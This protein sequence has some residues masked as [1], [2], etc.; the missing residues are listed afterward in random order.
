MTNIV[1][2]DG[3][4]D[5]FHSGHINFLQESKKQGNNLYV[6]V[7]SDDDAK[8][9]K[10][11]PVIPHQ[12]RII[13]LQQCKLVDKVIENPPLILTEEFI[14]EH[15]IDIVIHAD[16]SAQSDFFKVPIEL[17]IMKYIPYSKHISTTKIISKINKLYKCL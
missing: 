3:V 15:N 11:T 9:Y 12:D 17:G 5:L 7:I 10:R 8:S 1:Y 4:F 14:K 16:D 13:M 2:V 6:G